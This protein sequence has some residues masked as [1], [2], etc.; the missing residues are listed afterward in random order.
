MGLQELYDT[1]QNAP[2]EQVRPGEFNSAQLTGMLLA[3]GI[4]F[5]QAAVQV[6]K[7]KNDQYQQEQEAYKN[8]LERQKLVNAQQGQQQALNYINNFGANPASPIQQPPQQ[9]QGMSP[10]D[11]NAT[12][13]SVNAAP[14]MPVNP[15]SA[16]STPKRN[17]P[18]A[19]LDAARV[20]VANG[21]VDKA[22]ELLNKSQD[23]VSGANGIK[24]TQS[25]D[26]KTGQARLD[27]IP[28][29][30]E[31][32]SITPAEARINNT[33]IT[34]LAE[35][36]R[37]SVRE[38]RYLDDAN[39]YFDQFDKAQGRDTLTGAGSFLRRNAPDFLQ[40]ATLSQQGQT[41]K[42][43]IDKISGLIFQN[44][45]IGAGSNA[46]DAFKEQVKKSLPS[47]DITPEARQELILTK[48]R[49][50]SETIARSRFLS[51]WYKQNNKDIA[52]AEDAF[53]SYIE[54][55]NL[56]DKNGKINKD[57][58]KEIP[59]VV[60]E[61]IGNSSQPLQDNRAQIGSSAPS[62][63][64]DAMFADPEG[65]ATQSQSANQVAPKGV[66]TQQLQL[67]AKEAISKGADPAAVNARLQ[68]LI[69]AGDAK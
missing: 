13:A 64:V 47:V 67:W 9:G 45:V 10:V 62:D 42:Q 25:I 7:L 11:P 19:T 31:K 68:Q 3:S 50:N 1:Y 2:K 28:G 21:Q 4:P 69:G 39:K 26:P 16:P 24:Y 30:L 56:L 61:F 8:Q 49:E 27:V 54:N 6:A 41:A 37:S 51:E 58:L 46:T 5:G 22:V 65:V 52:G 38:L 12:L 44:R 18:Q 63:N 32:P 29:Q 33:K 35:D 14:T 43:E 34:K 55:E 15:G 66:N 59:S 23:V 40:N 20:L 53:L 57:L 17:V 36:A 60:R 48:T